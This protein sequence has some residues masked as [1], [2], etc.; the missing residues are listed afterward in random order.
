MAENTESKTVYKSKTANIG[1]SESMHFK[2]KLL[3]EKDFF[4]T[5]LDGYRLAASIAIFKELDISNHEL[6]NPKN[7][8]D[9]GGVDPDDFFKNAILHIF[10]QLKGQ[11]YDSLE[12][13]ADLGTEH[14]HK[15]TTE[16]DILD[17]KLLL[18]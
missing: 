15:I 4:S 16:N 3:V 12:K 5:M 2:L 14:L 13:F 17:I 10:P 1:L 6:K 11:E 7:M 18:E 8:Y 9:I